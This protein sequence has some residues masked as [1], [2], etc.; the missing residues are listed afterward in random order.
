[1]TSLRGRTF[2]KYTQQGAYHWDSADPTSSSYAPAAQARYSL[3]VDRLEGAGDVLD[4]GCGD[5]FLLG[6]AAA[7]CR[8]VV[9][10]EP[11]RSGAVLAREKLAGLAACDVLLASGSALPFS[12]GSFDVVV[13]AEVIEHLEDPG[14]TLRE[15]ARVLRPNGRI[16]VTT[17]RRLPNHWWDRENHVTEYTSEELRDLLAGH[18]AVVDVTHFISLR[19]WA[20]RKRLGKVFMRLWSRLISNPFRRT[21]NEPDRFGHLLAVG[22]RPKVQ[23]ASADVGPGP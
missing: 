21:G 23:P 18:F 1:M 6:R 16:I 15:V 19:W 17:P 11:E 7:V 5:G 10:I 3:I 9:G 13:M 2:T 8:R 20:V 22:G 12:S 14:A 4:V